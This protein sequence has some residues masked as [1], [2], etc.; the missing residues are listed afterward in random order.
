MISLIQFVFT[1]LRNL[2]EIGI[3]GKLRDSYNCKVRTLLQLEIMNMREE[4]ERARFQSWTIELLPVTSQSKNGSTH[5]RGWVKNFLT[6]FSK[7]CFISIIFWPRSNNKICR[8]LWNTYMFKR[9]AISLG[10]ETKNSHWR[11][12]SWPNVF[13]S[14]VIIESVQ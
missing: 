5:L 10:L 6:F 11:L 12:H 4:W 7:K 3:L 13:F 2:V 14:S 8:D 1:N 9:Q